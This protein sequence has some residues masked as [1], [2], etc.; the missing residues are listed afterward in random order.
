MARLMWLEFGLLDTSKWVAGVSHPS[1]DTAAFCP[2]TP[3]NA[4]DL[5][6]FPADKLFSRRCKPFYRPDQPF[7]AS[8]KLEFHSKSLF[9]A[10]DCLKIATHSPFYAPDHL[11]SPADNVSSPP[12][13]L[14]N[15]SKRGIYAQTQSKT[16]K[17]A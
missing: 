2:D 17:H 4:V 3:P 15:P 11:L 16:T 8:D 6:L 12:E 10:P 9:S 14:T 5:P 1:F 13:S 7:C